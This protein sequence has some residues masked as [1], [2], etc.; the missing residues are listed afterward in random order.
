MLSSNQHHSAHGLAEDFHG[1]LTAMPGT[2]QTALWCQDTIFQRGTKMCT[3]GVQSVHLV[4]DLHQQ[5]FPSIDA[6]D[7]DLDF[8]QIF[9]VEAVQAFQFVLLGHFGGIR[10]EQDRPSGG[11]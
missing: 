1:S 8:V 9:Q 10:R 11:L 3:I 2:R 4:S 5:D 6:L 7:L